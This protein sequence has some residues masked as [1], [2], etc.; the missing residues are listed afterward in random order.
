L[1]N[2]LLIHDPQGQLTAA[3]KVE[4]TAIR[5]HTQRIDHFDE[6]ETLADYPEKVKKLLRRLSRIRA[7]RLLS[8][9]L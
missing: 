5:Q 3:S 9:F 8:R 1:E 2:A 6:L 7:D 4:Q